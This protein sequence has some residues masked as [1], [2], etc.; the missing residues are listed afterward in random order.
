MFSNLFKTTLGGGSGPDG[1]YNALLAE[2][3]IKESMPEDK[4]I[5]AY[6]VVEMGVRASGGRFSTEQ[7]CDKFNRHNRLCQLNLIALTLA[8]LNIHILP[9]GK[10]MP[11]NNP[12]TLN[13]TEEDISTGIQYF[14]NKYKLSVKIEPGKIDIREWLAP[15]SPQKNKK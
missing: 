6:E 3:V 14:S 15:P 2:L 8:K 10:W 5:I 12:F 4:I 9:N 7:F 13:I 1:A 11:I